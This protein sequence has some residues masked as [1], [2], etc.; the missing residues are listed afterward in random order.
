MKSLQPHK[1]WLLLLLLFL[2]AVINYFDRQSLSILA[3][4]VQRALSLSDQGYAHIVSGFLL[5]SAI[6]YA[7]AGAIADRLGT[8]RAMAL[9]VTWWSLAE[10]AT[11]FVQSIPALWIARFNL[12]LGEPG[13]WVAAPK[14]VGESFPKEDRTLA[15]GIYTCGA[16]LGAII[17]LPIIAFLS[18][19][20]HWRTVFILDGAVGLLWLPCWLLFYRRPEPRSIL[21]LT[22]QDLATRPTKR[23][24]FI[25][26]LRRPSVLRL[27]VA[28]GLTDPVWYFYLFWFPKFLL[29]PEHFDLHR[30]ARA[31]WIVY[32]FAG[33]G[34]ILGGLAVKRLM[35]IGLPV[36]SSHL[37]M[38]AAAAILVLSSPIISTQH[39]LPS[40]LAIGAT[41]ALAHMCWLTNLTALI[42]NLFRSADVGTAAGIIAAGSGLGGM[43]AS[44]LLG[45]LVTNHGY[46]LAFWVMGFLHITALTIIWPLRKSDSN[47]AIRTGPSL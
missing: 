47:P 26:V 21:D 23:S 12:G 25:E 8:R 4:E 29:G 19:R 1:N 46:N 14:A 41:V 44:E 17:A 39:S 32:L 30:V 34:T 40:I 33:I 16:T 11:G 27:L 7:L 5:A 13:L 37:F 15:I 3:P 45:K 24:S 42:V 36:V 43:I 22:T 6:A 31:G 20:F 38:M 35:R 9:F 2:V 28:R 10:L 18:M